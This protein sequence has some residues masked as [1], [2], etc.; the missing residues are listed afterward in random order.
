M[1]A[2][3][4]F[5]EKP[6][7]SSEAAE[8][9]ILGAILL[10]NELIAQAAENLKPEDFYSPL[11]RK[12]YESMLSLFNKS[13]VID[14]I[15][16][17][18]ELKLLGYNP[19][20]IGGVATITNLT[21]GMP[22][23]DDISEY[24]KTV[25]EKAKIREL[26]NRCASITAMALEE[27]D[28]AE[29]ILDFA[30]ST[31]NEVCAETDKKGFETVGNVAVESL[32]EKIALREAAKPYSGLETGLTVID[33][34]T[35]GLQKTDLIVVGARPGI[36]KTSLLVGISEKACEIAPEAVIA[37]FSLEMSKKQLTDR[38]LC[39]SAQVS[40]NKF[41]RALFNHFEYERLVEAAARLGDYK[42][43]IDDTPGISPAKVRSKAM[44]LKAKHK[45]LDLIVVDFLQKMSPSRRSESVRLEVGQN[46][47][48]L[49][50][51]AKSLEVPVVAVSSLNRDC[52]KRNPPK[53]IMSD[54]SESNIIESEADIVAFLYREHYYRPEAN[55]YDAEIIFEKNRHGETGTKELKWI[56]EFTQFTNK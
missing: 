48:E 36:G 13:K 30:Q 39:S 40:S 46:A 55:P 54:L 45:R 17:T 16:V 50:D 38:M 10:C 41:K 51:I 27:T 1:T 21:Y 19:D 11:H 7:P 44:M 4:P 29:K 33:T 5:L 52:E 20:S 8:R 47:R 12:V 28:E 14:P 42:I 49:K 32:Y 3:A 53:P 2:H 23:F 31:I 24:V 18:E 34:V 22:H 6:L 26:V 56:G 9:T 25:R 43:E 35:G 37:I 15:I